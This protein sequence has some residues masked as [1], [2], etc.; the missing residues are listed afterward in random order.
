MRKKIQSRWTQVSLAV[1][2]LKVSGCAERVLFLCSSLCPARGTGEFIFVSVASLVQQQRAKL[3]QTAFS[4]G[5][6]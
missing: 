2:T 5:I 6:P 1:A 4:L 3:P